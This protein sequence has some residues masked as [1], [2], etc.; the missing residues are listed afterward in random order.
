MNYLRYS[1]NSQISIAESLKAY[2]SPKVIGELDEHY[3]KV[4][5][6]KGSLVWHSHEFE[7]EMFLIIKGELEMELREEVIHL[8][9]GDLFV[10]PAGV[11]HNPIAKEECLVMLIE[12]KTTM[13]TGS[14][15]HP[16]SKSVEAQLSG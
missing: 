14:V 13:H 3:I 2:W 8:S 5:K 16:K 1:K 4:A 12:K 15:N 10:V 6:L 7:D 11:E 9:T